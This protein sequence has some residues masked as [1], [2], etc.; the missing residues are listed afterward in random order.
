MKAGK[1]NALKTELAADAC[2]K[3]LPI[4]EY[5]LVMGVLNVTPD[6]F[7]DGGKFLEINKAVDRA[8]LMAEQG[9]DIIDIGGESTRPGARQV[10]VAEEIDRIQP[11][12]ERLQ[13]KHDKFI[14][15][16]TRKSEVAEIACKYGAGIVN[17]VS[18]LRH[19][20]KIA[21]I[22]KSHN[23]YLVLMHMLRT[24]ETMQVDIHYDDLVGD[25]S[26][27]LMKSADLAISYG[28][29][30]NKLILDPG[31]GF[32]KTVE[33]NF[34]LLKNIPRFKKLGYPLLIGASRKSFIG[35]T[36]NLTVEDRLEG[37]LAT[38]VFAIINGADIVR[39][40]DVLATVRAIKIIE[41]IR[42]S[43]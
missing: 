6:S 22:A 38:A 32:G 13:G 41:E 2:I 10:S 27:F 24:P 31:I 7:S 26:D 19:D 37:S 42:R 35:K 30:K 18:A 11:V 28:I 3:P 15:I 21:L 9:A 40:H 43:N 20:E 5:P 25:I 39:V 17:D 14:S 36:L 33:H 23:T 16:D 34:S 29:E 1:N 12:L 8:L 4:G